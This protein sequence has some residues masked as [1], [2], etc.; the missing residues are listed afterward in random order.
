MGVATAGLLYDAT[1]TNEYNVL[2]IL[3]GGGIGGAVAVWTS[4]VYAT[5]SVRVA[6]TVQVAPSGERGA[7]LR[8]RIGL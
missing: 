8:L 2:P 4:A 3:V 6:P 1:G 7:G 5:R